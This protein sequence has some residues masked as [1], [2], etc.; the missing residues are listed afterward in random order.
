MESLFHVINL[1]LQ[2]ITSIP[3]HYY[4][5]FGVVV[6]AGITT[7]AIVAYRNYK[8]LY[9]DVERFTKRI[10]AVLI[11]LI[12]LLSTLATYI[13][14]NSQSITGIL[15]SSYFANLPTFILPAF[16]AIVAVAHNFYLLGGN[17]LFQKAYDKVSVWAN[18]K[19]TPQQSIFKTTASHTTP[20]ETVDKPST[21]LF[22]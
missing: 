9:N 2:A 20:D 11:G 14:T 16:A 15:H 10:A 13:L 22:N 18:A 19:Q 1:A 4:Y 21:G 3:A 17:K 12:G 7:S 8:R 5:T 6:A